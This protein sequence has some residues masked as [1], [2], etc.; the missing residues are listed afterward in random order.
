MSSVCLSAVISLRP[1]IVCVTVMLCAAGCRPASERAEPRRVPLPV[2]V[3]VPRSRDQVRTTEVAFGKLMARQSTPLGFARPGVV[4]SVTNSEAV[5]RGDVLATLETP[6]LD[7]QK[8][9]LEEALAAARSGAAVSGA[10]RGGASGGEAPPDGARA[11]RTEALRRQLAQLNAQYAAFAIV[12][13]HDGTIVR[14][15]V[16]PGQD[17]TPGRVAVQLAA[18]GSLIVRAGL[19]DRAAGGL[20]P[21]QT[22]WVQ[23]DGETIVCTLESVAAAQPSGVSEVVLAFP[24]NVE[25][26]WQQIGDAVEIRFFAEQT[27]SGCWLPLGALQRDDGDAWSVLTVVRQR[28]ARQRVEVERL[29]GAWA[30]VRATFPDARVIVDGGHRVTDGQSVRPVDVTAEFRVPSGREI[31]E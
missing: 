26:R 10:A 28:V 24:D 31:T 19:P 23:V 9:Q 17:V 27:V 12:A 5:Q 18:A 30:F 11:A 25:D 14:R 3:I 16:T 7:R 4:R 15:R 13:P 21:E 2:H 20:R 29:E 6:E 22:V 8:Q 1:M